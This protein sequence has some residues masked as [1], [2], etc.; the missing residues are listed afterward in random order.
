MIDDQLF[1]NEEYPPLSPP[2]G[3][4]FRLLNKFKGDLSFINLLD[5][6]SDYLGKGGKFLIV[7]TDESG[8]GVSSIDIK[9]DSNFVHVQ[10]DISATWAITHNL[11]KQP[12]VNVVD[13][14]GFTALVDIN[15]TSNDELEII[16]SIPFSGIAYLN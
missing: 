15:R 5:T 12:S 11:H 13:A 1:E 8:I 10:V 14:D 6:F 3:K 16:S 4:P 9:S 2:S 7:K